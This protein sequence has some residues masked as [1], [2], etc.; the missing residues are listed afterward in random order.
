MFTLFDQ[1]FF[2][3]FICRIFW[4][5]WIWPKKYPNCQKFGKYNL[6]FIIYENK[7]LVNFIDF[8][9]FVDVN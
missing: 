1:Q 2:E 3:D 6:G 8:H 5:I 7:K 9:M 4:K